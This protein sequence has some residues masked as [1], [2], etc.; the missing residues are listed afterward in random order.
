MSAIDLNDDPVTY[1]ISAGNEA[2]KF[3]IDS[4]TGEITLAARL[5][6][7]AGTTY[8]LTVGTADG[9]SGTTSVTVTVTVAAADCTGGTVV[10]RPRQRT[11]PGERLRGFADPAGRPGGH[12]DAGLERGYGDLKL[13]RRDGGRNADAGH[14][15][16]TL[17]AAVWQAAFHRG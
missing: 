12:G 5:G 9:V 15:L 6:S 3:S 17:R 13:G 8:M 2:G 16:W 1:S 4:S 14:G 7:A 10:T 11:R